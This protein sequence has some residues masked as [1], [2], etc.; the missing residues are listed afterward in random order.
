MELLISLVEMTPP[1]HSLQWCL[2]C[3]SACTNRPHRF[4]PIPLDRAG[5]LTA[6][7]V[8]FF[9][10]YFQLMVVVSEAEFPSAFLDFCCPV[11]H[12]FINVSTQ[13]FLTHSL[14]HFLFVILSLSVSFHLCLLFFCCLLQPDKASVSC[15]LL[16]LPQLFPP[17]WMRPRSAKRYLVQV[18]GALMWLCKKP[19]TRPP[20]VSLLKVLMYR[21]TEKCTKH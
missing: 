9:T 18:T 17:Q 11:T 5:L 13:L 4:R 3:S 15:T 14:C 20:Q 7:C 6:V 12:Y 1:P 2:L 10:P 16:S 19:S 21:V 8:V